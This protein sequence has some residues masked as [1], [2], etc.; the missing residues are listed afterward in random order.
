M[1][2]VLHRRSG[3]SRRRCSGLPGPRRLPG[4]SPVWAARRPKGDARP[5]RRR[6]SAN[7]STLAGGWPP[8]SAPRPAPRSMSATAPLWTPHSPPSPIGGGRLDIVVTTPS[9]N[10]RKPLLDYVDDEFDQVVGLNCKGSFHVIRAAGRVMR[11]HRRGSII[12]PFS[13]IRAQLVEPGQSVCAA[14]KASIFQL[15][16]TAAAELDPVRRPRQRRRPPASSRRR[17][18]PPSATTRPGTPPTPT[19][20]S[21]AAGP[22]RRMVG[23]TV[24]LASDASSYATGSLLFVDGSLDGGRWAVV[25]P[26][27]EPRA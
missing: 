15:V 16:H 1:V 17:S 13:F 23:P 22:P 10:G 8:S 18:P 5:R 2:I 14:T 3:R 9:V 24:F 26:G 11:A 19:R 4:G 20:A 12:I 21:S 6:T 25:P 27:M 7:C